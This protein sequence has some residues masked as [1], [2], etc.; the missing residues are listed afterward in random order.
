VGGIGY[1]GAFALGL[2][3][4]IIASPCTGPVLTGIIFYI[5]Q[6][7]SVLLGAVVGSTYSLGLGVPFFLAGAFAVSLPKSG[8]W[9]VW[10]KSFFGVNLLVMALTY[11][12][13]AFPALSA[14]ARPGTTF[15]LT[16]AL[17]VVLGLALGAIHLSWDDG[18]VGTKIRKVAGIALVVPAAFLYWVARDLPSLPAAG[19]IAAMDGAAAHLSWEHEESAAVAKARAEKRPL[20]VDFTAEWCVACKK[21]SKETFSDPRVMEKCG[22]FVAV[23]VDATNDED[24]QV[25]AVKGKYKVVGLPTVVIYDSSGAERKRFNDFV[26]PDAFV[27]AACGIN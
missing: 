15:L 3:L 5:G 12:K 2:V 1:G 14:L 4:G 6:K 18:G 24:P 21:M 11:A 13:N 16:M 7:Q 27:T 25:D 23:K 10:V 26:G 9:M 17:L 20:L 19:E 8:K 22:H